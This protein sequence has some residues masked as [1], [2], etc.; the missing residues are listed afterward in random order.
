MGSASGATATALVLLVVLLLYGSD[1]KHARELFERAVN[2]VCG[3]FVEPAR[4][5]WVDITGRYRLEHAQV[6]PMVTL[7]DNWI[8]FT[9]RYVVPYTNRRSVKDRLFSRILDDIDQSGGRRRAGRREAA[10][11]RP[12]GARRAGPVAASGP[13][14]GLLRLRAGP[15]GR[16]QPWGRPQARRPRGP[17]TCEWGQPYRQVRTRRRTAG[18]DLSGLISA[19]A[20]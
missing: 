9:I 4:T 17:S 18:R 13:A 8:E 19:R 5:T 10:R 16:A 15:E 6:A 12:A 3:S 7:I 2:D 1:H 11:R 14:T 20:W